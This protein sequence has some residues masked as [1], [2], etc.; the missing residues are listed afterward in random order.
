MAF[1]R[2]GSRANCAGAGCNARLVYGS[3]VWVQETDGELPLGTVLCVACATEGA[4]RDR[5]LLDKAARNEGLTEREQRR[6]EYIRSQEPGR[7]ERARQWR[8]IEDSR[9]ASSEKLVG[10]SEPEIHRETRLRAK[11]RAELTADEVQWLTARDATRRGQ[12]RRVAREVECDP[13]KA[14]KSKEPRRG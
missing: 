10:P 14:V 11:P 2:I 5:A 9:S 12:A 1:S 3:P 6:V 7:L 4:P 8:R 13:A